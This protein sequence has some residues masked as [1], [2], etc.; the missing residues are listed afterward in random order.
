M[1]KKPGTTKPAQSNRIA[2]DRPT[3]NGGESGAA[4]KGV[5]AFDNWLD[6]KLR[7]AYSSVLEEP[8]PDDLIRLIQEKLKD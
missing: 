6:E 8:I 4:R 7:S 5:P 3:A 2:D 1:I